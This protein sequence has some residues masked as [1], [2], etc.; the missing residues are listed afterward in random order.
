MFYLNIIESWTLKRLRQIDE[1]LGYDKHM[2]AMVFGMQK[3]QVA[4]TKYGR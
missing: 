4:Q 3:K 1:A 2:N